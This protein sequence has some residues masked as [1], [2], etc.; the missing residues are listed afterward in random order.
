MKIKTISKVSI[1]ISHTE[2]NKKL[3]TPSIFFFLVFKGKATDKKLTWWQE[4]DKKTSLKLRVNH[5]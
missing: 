4:D 1:T 3:E 2:D 5:C